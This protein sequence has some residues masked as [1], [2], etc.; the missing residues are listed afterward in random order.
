MSKIQL[1]ILIFSEMENIVMGF[2]RT[3]GITHWPDWAARHGRI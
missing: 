3:P 2:L 1:V